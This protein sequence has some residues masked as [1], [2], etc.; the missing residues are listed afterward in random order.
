MV[1]IVLVV[2]WWSQETGLSITRIPIPTMTQLIY[3]ISPHTMK[4]RHIRVNTVEVLTKDLSVKPG[5]R[6][7]MNS[8]LVTIK[9]LKMNNIHIIH[10]I[11]HNNHIVVS[12]VE[13]HTLALIVKQGIHFLVTIT[14]IRIKTNLH[15]TK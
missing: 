10:R 4:Y 1:V 7:S 6:L 15:S 14:T 12:T 8:F 5:T 2:A 9:V 11:S 13:V 3:S